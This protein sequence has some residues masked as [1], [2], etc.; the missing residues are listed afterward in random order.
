MT[1]AL[2]RIDDAPDAALYTMNPNDLDD[3]TKQRMFRT[4]G[5]CPMRA[6]CYE[7]ASN[8]TTFEGIAAGREWRTREQFQSTH[9]REF[10]QRQHDEI[11]RR[12]EAMYRLDYND[13][14]I[15]DELGITDRTV[16]RIR[17]T[18]LKLPGRVTKVRME[19]A[20]RKAG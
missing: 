16:W 6:E 13:R 8:D 14:Q 5:N 11:K 19:R 1:T 4:C 9:S 20:R 15:A 2:C 18:E 7:W 17:T 10:R 3:A 12:I